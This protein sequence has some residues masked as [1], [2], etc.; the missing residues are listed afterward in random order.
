MVSTFIMLQAGATYYTFPNSSSNRLAGKRGNSDSEPAR[1]N[2]NANITNERIARI[3]QRSLV[4]FAKFV[5]FALRNACRRITSYRTWC[6]LNC[7]TGNN[8]RC[9]SSQSIM[10]WKTSSFTD[11]LCNSW[12]MP[13]HNFRVTS[14]LFLDA[15]L[16]KSALPWE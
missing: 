2:L 12:Y 9:R 3:F 6:C 10:N 7:V 8:Y 13:S 4:K 1:K 5:E 11:S 14:G 15:A 16:A